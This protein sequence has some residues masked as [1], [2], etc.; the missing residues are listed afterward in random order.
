M[1]QPVTRTPTMNDVARLAQVAQ[2]TVS[3][4]INNY[5]HVKPATRERVQKAVEALGYRPNTSAR[6]LRGSR[7]GIIALAVPEIAA[8][9]FAELANL[10]QHAAQERGL[11]LL[12][13]QTSGSAE[14]EREV[15]DGFSLNVIDGLILSPLSLTADD[16]RAESP[17]VPTVLLGERIAD[18][19]HVHISMDNE[20]AAREVTDLLFAGGCRRVAAL[21]T[22]TLIGM[23]PAA[24]RLDGYRAS[25]GAHG[26]DV[27]PSLEIPSPEWSHEAGYRA[28]AAAW[29]AGAVFDGLFCFN[30]ALALGAMRAL[31]ERGLSI[32][33]DVAVA[34]WDD[35]V[36]AAYSSPALTTVSPDKAF[37][38]REAIDRLLAMTDGSDEGDADVVAPHA[39]VRRDSTR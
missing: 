35:I 14:D 13:D 33:E 39:L 17:R 36:D 1:G 27:D 32:P 38:A 11:T 3:N 24:R 15:L 10:I 5:E 19:G 9:Y 16:L 23:S 8:P 34:G 12:I 28:V 30:D 25:V 37:I 21:G 2:R 6:H 29:D 31:R 22:Q 26:Q 18:V 7:T 20:R 4:V